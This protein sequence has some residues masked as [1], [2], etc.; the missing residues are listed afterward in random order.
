MRMLGS[1]SIRMGCILGE[2]RGL[3]VGSNS[4]QGLRVSEAVWW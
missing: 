3:V 1:W 2:R 4:E